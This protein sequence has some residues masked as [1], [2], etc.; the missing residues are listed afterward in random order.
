VESTAS[1]ASLAVV[2]AS[3]DHVAPG[4]GTVQVCYPRDTSQGHERHPSR[5]GTIARSG[6]ELRP[7]TAGRPAVEIHRSAR[8]RR[9]AAAAVRDGTVVVRLPA[10]LPADAEERTIAT[11]VRKVTGQAR[12]ERRGGDAAL[13]RR[14]HTLADRYLDG[15]RAVEVVWS[16]RMQ[17]LYGSCTVGDGRIR[18]SSRLAA[19]PDYVLD[20]VLVHELAHLQAPD[21]SSWFRELE[22]RYPLRAKADGYLE[23]FAAGWLGASTPDVLPLPVVPG[24]EGGAPQP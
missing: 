21:H 23:G 20:A 17:R 11:L 8:R 6:P 1:G 7:A 2:R 16:D 22:D 9:T 15:V 13:T 14:A 19:A 4:V 18:I 10:G 3:H 5:S 12:A 24:A